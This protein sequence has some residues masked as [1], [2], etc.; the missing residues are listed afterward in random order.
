MSAV[1]NN[2]SRRNLKLNIIIFV[3]FILVSSITAVF[4]LHRI[5]KVDRKSVV[6][7]LQAV[8]VSINKTINKNWADIRFANTNDW[9]NNEIVVQNTKKL[10]QAKSKSNPA[11]ERAIINELRIF[12][13]PRLN[14]YSAQGFFII[15]LDKI[16]LASMRDQNIGTENLICK[17]YPER[18]IKVIKGK[19]Q[20]IP[21]IPSDVP[22]ENEAGQLIEHYPTMFMLVP[23]IDNGETIAALSVRF[24]PLNEF[25]AITNN[26]RMGYTGETYILN[27]EGHLLT[28]SRFNE[29]LYKTPLLKEGEH[30]ILNIE[31]R[32]PQVN[33]IKNEKSII[34]LERQPLTLMA[35]EI[36]K[37]HSGSSFVAY[38]DYRGVPVLGAWLWDPILGIGFA[39]E[40]DESEAMEAYK[41]AKNIII[42]LVLLIIVFSI[43]LFFIIERNNRLVIKKTAY[44][45][46]YLDA[47]F[48][49]TVDPLI[50]T[51]KIGIIDF[52]NKAGCETFQ[53][54]INELIGRNI[55]TL[56]K[57]PLFDT[58]EVIKIQSLV[59]EKISGQLKL[60]FPAVKK[61]GTE[62]TI[63]IAINVMTI[64]NKLI[65]ILAI[66]DITTDKEFERT[67]KQKQEDVEK[68]NIELEKARKVAL[69][70][71]QDSDIQKKRT[72]EALSE[73]EKST[74]EIR[75][76]SEAIKQS[77]SSV[78]ITDTKGNIEFVNQAFLNITG[79][80]REEVINQNPRFLKSGVLN[81]QFY[82]DLWKTITS[83]DVWSSEF[84]NKKKNGEIFWES[85][86]ISPIKKDNDE[87]T[88]FIAVKENITEKKRIEE[89]LKVS[90]S[91]YR[92][93][94]KAAGDAIFVLEDL[95]FVECN[96]KF[97]TLF[98]C[99]EDQIIGQHA[100][101]ISP[102]RQPNGKYSKDEIEKIFT[103]L[104]ST[105][106]QTFEW[107]N[108][109]FDGQP[110]HT[111]VSL[112][113]LETDSKVLIHGIVHDITDRKR[114]QKEL[115]SR[116]NRLA[117]HNLILQKLTQENDSIVNLESAY[118]AITEAAT[119][120]LGISRSGIW[121]YNKDM[122]AI[123]CANLYEANIKKH[124]LGLIFK[125]D[126]FPAYF[127]SLYKE[128]ILTVNDARNDSRTSEF[129]ETYFK[130]F[131]IYSTL[132][133]PLWFR[134]KVIGVLCNE[135]TE[136]KRK[137][138]ADEELF[139]RSLADF[140]AL[141]IEPNE[142][143][144][145]QETAEYATQ[146]KSV[147]LANMSHEIRTPMNAIIGF[148][149]IL[150]KRIK[151][152]LNKD[153]L[154]SIKSSGK[155]L[156]SLINDVLDFSK[157]EA[158]KLELQLNKVNV[159][160][161]IK[162][163]ENIFT[164][165]TQEKDLQ[166]IC[167]VPNEFPNYLWLDELRIKQVLI[168]FT[169]NAIKFTSEGSISIKL[170]FVENK[171]KDFDITFSV[172]D[173]GIGIPKKEHEK[174]FE[175][176]KQQEQ[177]DTRKFGGTG[178]GLA[179]SSKLVNLMNGYLEL[180]SRP[181]TGS[182]FSFTIPNVKI[183]EGK[184][185]EFEEII[186]V[187]NIIFEKASILVVDD[188]ENNRKV[189]SGLLSDLALDIIEAESGQQAIEIAK[190]E[191]PDLILMDIRMPEMDG[192]QTLN[193]IKKVKSIKEIPIIAL[194]ASTFN[195]AVQKISKSG[196]N[197]F[198]PKPFELYELI[199][200]L[201]RFLPYKRKIGAQTDKKSKLSLKK[202]IIINNPKLIEE[203]KINCTPLIND[204]EKMQST[205]LM[206][207]LGESIVSTA[208]QHKHKNLEENG[209]E[210]LMAVNSFNV[211]KIDKLFND[212]KNMIIN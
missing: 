196:F 6:K 145:A 3:C 156:L 111:T 174:I 131:N 194:T 63:R 34:Q 127:N 11:E 10:L 103:D 39:T 25:S 91:R 173:T 30:S 175:A 81:N 88:H 118:K 212:F 191:K 83:G 112:S 177:Q 94:F 113:L 132:D 169:N 84:A 52:I 152:P 165:K 60:D 160:S 143:K 129:T 55:N 115:E 153:Y 144:I 36:S 33:L 89:A 141:A 43:I 13:E 41:N 128:Y 12:F 49:N 82:K 96:P 142:R 211:E 178:L 155:T 67:L 20:F 185:D 78:V 208:S 17:Y 27:T 4:E 114:N 130:P 104:L 133:I 186:D 98:K 7:S 189:V 32:N 180:K 1:I 170:S 154:E 9:A 42:G 161:L 164:I 124:S 72:Q 209:H 140:I 23:I 93:I 75:K 136:K 126:E 148:T 47:I 205:S 207:K 190:K 99:T 35:Q 134:G 168:N 121:L 26:G 92:N 65:Y 158:G 18:F 109:N 201:I 206:K 116:A 64:D 79:Y 179:I 77:H 24:N 101:I 204:L 139:G 157:I 68:T 146:A 38:R 37:K 120:G 14:R 197:G 22:L 73:L 171:P 80:S 137:W 200:T 110:V 119:A 56:L 51:D 15:S 100:G 188:V 187:D 53:Y 193:A 147:F 166:L 162:E 76:L 40:I 167:I 8:L 123:E 5:E 97:L 176:F 74:E 69:S 46:K 50:T 19:Q 182:T 90:M 138:E 183:V 163:I 21:P 107:E 159:R 151:D 29:Q 195:I 2:K 106:S 87:I 135:Q 105:G 181:G 86:V 85:A 66:H 62:F 28:E 16:S 48:N 202:E 117:K 149:E 31:I 44:Q 192:Y 54:S 57:K 203:L 95:K 198:I 108:Q 71:M 122:S 58:N 102:E 61:N 210:L 184:L 172:I 70:I 59:K 150:H 125:K 199:N 45:E